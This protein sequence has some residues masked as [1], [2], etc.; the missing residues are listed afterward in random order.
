VEALPDILSAGPNVPSMNANY[1][2]DGFA[3]HGATVLTNTRLAAITDEGA[4]VEDVATGEKRTLAADTV[5]L[6]LGFRPAASHAATISTLKTRGTK[7]RQIR[8]RANSRR[9]APIRRA[10]FFCFLFIL[11]WC[12]PFHSCA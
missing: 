2:R 7:F 12:S 11:Q 1:L 9:P 5:V 6:A 4:E 3:Y 8:P 10:I